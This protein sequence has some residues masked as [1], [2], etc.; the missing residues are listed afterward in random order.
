MIY[1]HNFG[2][3]SKFF[4]VG[5]QKE[6]PLLEEAI[7][8]YAYLSE[9]AISSAG[10][11]RIQGTSSAVLTKA[12][13]GLDRECGKELAD[14]ALRAGRENA[15]RPYS[16]EGTLP[17]ADIPWQQSHQIESLIRTILSSI[18]SD[19]PE[20]SIS[21][22]ALTQ[23][24]EVL[25]IKFSNGEEMAL[26]S[27]AWRE[28][29]LFANILRAGM[30]AAFGGWDKEYALGFNRADAWAG[31]AA[32]AMEVHLP[33][34]PA[35]HVFTAWKGERAE[36]MPD[37][38]S[39]RCYEKVTIG[40]RVALQGRKVE[41]CVQLSVAGMGGW[42]PV[43]EGEI[44]QRTEEAE[45]MK[46]KELNKSYE[47]DL[48]VEMV[49]GIVDMPIS[50]LMALRPGQR[51]EISCAGERQTILRV[52]GTP[53]AL[54]TAV[55]G[56]GPLVFRCSRLLWRETEGIEPGEEEGKRETFPDSARKE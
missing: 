48:P 50:A 22:A 26:W 40:V 7:A 10:D 43:A 33:G 42:L 9:G 3:L 6:V 5:P 47:Q 31:I 15:F 27:P 51:F 34:I 35:H 28:P 4:G 55:L 39:P 49:L 20:V 29:K 21:E 30:K 38:A 56:E 18:F 17:C 24:Q 2:M 19:E 41:R 46:C 23:T 32:C 11:R 36:V 13:F 25:C 12:L 14:Y 8:G 1:E 37:Q 54:G 45:T 52:G 53:V 16:A 44:F